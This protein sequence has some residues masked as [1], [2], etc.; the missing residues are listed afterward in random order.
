MANG[1]TYKSTNTKITRDLPRFQEDMETSLDME[2]CEEGCL[3]GSY[4]IQIIAKSLGGICCAYLFLIMVLVS[5]STK[6]T[7]PLI[8]YHCKYKFSIVFK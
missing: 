2:A 6:D 4:F 3:K 7:S 5:L 1:T 8:S